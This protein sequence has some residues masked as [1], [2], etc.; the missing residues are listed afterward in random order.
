MEKNVSII[1]PVCNSAKYL[2]ECI[3]S[4]C[5]QTLKNIEIICIND[6]SSDESFEILSSFEKKDSRIRL[7]S[8]INEG[9]GCALNIGLN[10][11]GGEYIGFVEPKDFVDKKM[12]EKLYALSKKSDADVVKSSYFKYFEKTA[13]DSER[14]EKVSFEKYCKPPTWFFRITECPAFF[15]FHPSIWSAL[16]KRTFL[17]NNSIRFVEAKGFSNV[18][19]PFQVETM[20]LAQKIVYTGS[21]YYF[22]R[23]NPCMDGIA[24][25]LAGETLN[26]AHL[27]DRA[28]EMHEI[29]NR[30]KN[31]DRNILANIYKRELGFVRHTFE[32]SAQNEAIRTKR[33]HFPLD[34]FDIKNVPY[35]IQLR[36]EK[37]VSRMD[38]DIIKN[39]P[40]FDSYERNFYNLPISSVSNKV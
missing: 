27:Y 3:K 2:A 30:C 20:L 40:A 39:N 25:S 37:M 33:G 15:S 26:F 18:D 31:R 32:V 13:K 5:A 19:N 12:F 28:D 7:V 16:Y 24:G 10:L 29:L 34:N 38:G 21:A 17:N 6:G 1:V 22:R 14:K 4:I 8:K 35:E 11:A 36:I 23:Q 9:Y